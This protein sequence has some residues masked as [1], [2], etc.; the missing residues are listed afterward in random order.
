MLPVALWFAG[1]V[2]SVGIICSFELGLFVLVVSWLLDGLLVLYSS[3]RV[4]LV[5]LVVFGAGWLIWLACWCFLGMIAWVG[6]CSIWL[7][8]LVVIYSGSLFRCLAICGC[9]VLLVLLV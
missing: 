7:G 6:L 1:G 9:C 4:R 3:V 5:L 8:W 2:N